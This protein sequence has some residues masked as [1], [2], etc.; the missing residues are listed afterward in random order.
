[1]KIINKNKR[2]GLL[3]A[4]NTKTNRFRLITQY[5]SYLFLFYYESCLF[6]I[7]GGINGKE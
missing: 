1:M 3:R 7:G 4:W 6:S 5:I 2:S